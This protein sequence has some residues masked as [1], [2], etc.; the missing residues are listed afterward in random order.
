MSETKL[1]LAVVMLAGVAWGQ[2]DSTTMTGVTAPNC[3]LASDGKYY[4]V[5]DKP[6][7]LKCGKYESREFISDDKFPAG[8]WTCLPIEHTVTEK[9]W[10][11]LM[12]RLKKLEAIQE[13]HDATQYGWAAS[14]EY[15]AHCQNKKPQP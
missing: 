6:A 14:Y 2:Q 9:E 5:N 4:C 3:S 8:H 7:P 10:Q 12:A 1:A 15:A 11:E 13:A